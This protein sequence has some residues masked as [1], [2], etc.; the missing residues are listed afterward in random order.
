MKKLSVTIRIFIGSSF[1]GTK[2]VWL[3]TENSG[4]LECYTLRGC[5]QPKL[6]EN[7]NSQSTRYE[8]Q[9]H[10]IYNG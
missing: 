5:T 7:K 9:K 6:L 10:R 3:V 2:D 8:N 1:R 4:L